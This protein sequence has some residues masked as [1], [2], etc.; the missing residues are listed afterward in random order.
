MRA[1]G[2]GGRGREGGGGATSLRTLAAPILIP[3][4]ALGW[5]HGR[6]KRATDTHRYKAIKCVFLFFVIKEASAWPANENQTGL[7]CVV[8]AAA[9]DD[10]WFIVYLQNLVLRVVCNYI[11]WVKCGAAFARCSWSEML[12]VAL[13]AHPQK[14]NAVCQID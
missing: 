2:A 4:V 9:G 14:R 5:E 10:S 13:A 8:E 6:A 3:S 7:N 12:V 11:V 1:P